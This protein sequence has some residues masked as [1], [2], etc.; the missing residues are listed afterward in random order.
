VKQVYTMMHGQKNIK[1]YYHV[2]M[3]VLTTRISWW[4]F[5]KL[6]RNCVLVE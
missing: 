5:I 2:H 6:G 3:S 4:M 1:L